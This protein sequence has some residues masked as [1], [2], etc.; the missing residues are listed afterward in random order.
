MGRSET[1][2]V[3]SGTRCCKS[4]TKWDENGT[5][6]DEFYLLGLCLVSRPQEREPLFFAGFSYGR[7]LPPCKMVSSDRG[8][9]RPEEI[10]HDVDRP[11]IALTPTTTTTMGT[12]C[13]TWCPTSCPPS[14]ASERPESGTGLRYQLWTFVIRSCAVTEAADASPEG[15]SDHPAKAGTLHAG[16]PPS[17]GELLGLRPERLSTRCAELSSFPP[18]LTARW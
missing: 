8:K 5:Q 13:L 10:G 7:P 18:S 16:C 1:E 12:W 2:G 14:P 6:W 9:N 3:K 11:K 4:G 15:A 17:L